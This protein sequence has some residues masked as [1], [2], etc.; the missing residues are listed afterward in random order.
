MEVLKK[1][2]DEL[3]AE[4]AVD[5]ERLDMLENRTIET[6]ERTLEN[7]ERT[8]VTERDA[9]RLRTAISIRLKVAQEITDQFGE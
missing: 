5:Q 3:L 7:P 8:D 4:I 9:E 2:R 1:Y 6:F